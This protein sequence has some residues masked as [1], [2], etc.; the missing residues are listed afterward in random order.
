MI[1][2]N[3]IE[4]LTLSSVE[5]I[6]RIVNI[7]HTLYPHNIIQTVLYPTWMFVHRPGCL[8]IRPGRVSDTGERFT[9]KTSVS[10]LEGPPSP[11]KEVLSEWD[12]NDR[13]WRMKKGRTKKLPQRVR[14]HWLI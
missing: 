11:F 13:T 10:T 4:Q 3:T 2:C 5:E 6:L 8:E 1:Y 9:E 14:G 7:I 12:S